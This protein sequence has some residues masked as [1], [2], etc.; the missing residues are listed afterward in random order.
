[1]R[2]KDVEIINVRFYYTRVSD[3]IG[4]LSYIL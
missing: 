3:M 1:M 4:T 2:K